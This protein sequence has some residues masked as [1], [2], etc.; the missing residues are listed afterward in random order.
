MKAGAAH[1]AFSAPSRGVVDA[2]FV[3]ALKAGG[4]IHGGP[5]E[6]DPGTG[7]YSA[8]ILDFDDNSIEVMHRRGEGIIPGQS[9]QGSEA[10]RVLSWQKETAESTVSQAPQ[11]KRSN[12]R[13]VVTNVTKPTVMVANPSTQTS[14]GGDSSSKSLMGTLLG[15]A[16]GAAVAYAMTKG[17]ESGNQALG[18]FAYQAVEA[19]KFHVASSATGSQ[20]SYPRS[21][22]S[23]TSQTQLQALEYPRSQHSIAS[24]GA[25][26]HDAS[27]SH[28]TTNRL[29]ITAPPPPQASTLIETFIPPSEVPRYRRPSMSR[30]Q[31]DGAL[32]SPSNRRGPS[33]LSLRSKPSRASSAAKTITQ[34]YFLPSGRSSVVTEVRHPRDVPLPASK[35][36]SLASRHESD[37]RRLALTPKQHDDHGTVLDSVAPSDSISQ[38]G[39]KKPRH[40]KRST[41]HSSRAGTQG[42]EDSSHESE[43]TAKAERN[44][45]G[46]RRGSIMSLPIK[47]S[48]VHRSVVSFLPGM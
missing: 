23:H 4:R 10:K 24:H 25:R 29:T 37:L 41:R 18:S 17:E 42:D 5:A 48:S 36:T 16:A 6:R 43:K 8:A 45:V 31:T 40:S 46:V 9:D 28:S 38:A 21:T 22:I 14:S 3:A 19:A 12:P 27:P 34:A 13:V 32:P 47:S 33:Q 11:L 15:A 26:S 30:S 7:Y 39:S 20:Q 44:Q 35:A 1:I 2:F